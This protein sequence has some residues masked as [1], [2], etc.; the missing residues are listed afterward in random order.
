LASTPFGLFPFLSENI[1]FL[2]AA[3]PAVGILEDVKSVIV[4]EPKN[5][6][7]GTLIP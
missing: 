7:I 6:K 2:T 3:K 4:I 1:L 5:K